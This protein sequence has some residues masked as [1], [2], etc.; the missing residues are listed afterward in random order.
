[1]LCGVCMMRRSIYW[2]NE[3]GLFG[4][5]VLRFAS[6]LEDRRAGRCCKRVDSC[7]GSYLRHLYWFQKGVDATPPSQHVAGS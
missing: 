1:M 4:T 3:Q 5:E 7:M 6:R 2:V